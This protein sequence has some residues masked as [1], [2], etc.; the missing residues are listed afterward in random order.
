MLTQ[1]AL[2]GRCP[3]TL[4]L[5]CSQAL[6][7]AP[8]LP[9]R[10]TGP[11]RA[12]GGRRDLAGAPRKRTLFCHTPVPTCT[13]PGS[14]VPLGARVSRNSQAGQALW[15][16]GSEAGGAA[17]RPA[18]HQCSPELTCSPLAPAPPLSPGGPTS[19]WGQKR[20]SAPAQ[21]QDP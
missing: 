16:G 10:P 12:G 21:A 4:W 11:C 18:P 6:T 14:R 17:L 9:V 7:G 2:E 19:P 3:Q 20:P 13:H 1:P 5:P 15:V 8:A